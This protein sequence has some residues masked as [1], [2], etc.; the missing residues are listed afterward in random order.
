MAGNQRANGKELGGCALPVAR[1]GKQKRQAQQKR[2]EQQSWQG[3]QFHPIEQ[4]QQQGAENRAAR[5]DAAGL[6]GHSQ[7]SFKRPADAAGDPDG[8]ASFQNAVPGHQGGCRN[9]RAPACHVIALN[10]LYL[11]CA[12]QTP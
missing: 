7:Q 3:W 11:L 5:A 8:H 10:C 4:G 6:A 1:H 9:V 2:Q 12:N